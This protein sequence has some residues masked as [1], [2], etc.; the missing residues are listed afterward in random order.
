MSKI[1]ESDECPKCGWNPYGNYGDKYSMKFPDK[2]QISF[3]NNQYYKIGKI[4]KRTFPKIENYHDDSCEEYSGHSW[5]EIH[6]CPYCK[7]KFWLS[8]SDY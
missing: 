6:C 1:D 4:F 2:W 7:I 3:D 5:K 8:N